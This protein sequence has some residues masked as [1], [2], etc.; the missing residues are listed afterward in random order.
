MRISAATAKW[1][2]ASLV[3]FG[4]QSFLISTVSAAL[5]STP[6]ALNTGTGPNAGRWQGSAAID[7]NPL[8]IF[9]HEVEAVVEWAAFAPVPGGGLHKFQ[10][11]LDAHHPGAVNPVGNLSNEVIYAYEIVSVANANPGISLL[12]V[13]VDANDARGSVGPT[14]I[15]L[16]GGTAA[17]SSADQGTSMAWQFA[18]PLVGAGGKSQILVFSSPFV[19]ELDNLTVLSGAA[20]PLLSP[21]VG[22]PADLIFMGEIP[23]P[24]SLALVVLGAAAVL[25]ARRRRK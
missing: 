9:G 1:P 18:G 24:A 6:L 23:E 5:M 2:L 15:A 8:P 10:Q 22:S 16:T 14:T 7:V 12:T 19:P 4:V 13:G 21:Q 17:S 20:A 11:Y 3:V 25:S